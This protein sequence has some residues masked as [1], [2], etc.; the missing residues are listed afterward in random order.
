ML[1]IAILFRGPVRPSIQST[2]DR[3][4]EV[5]A[6]FAGVQNAEITTYLATWRS[7]KHLNATDLIALNLFDNVIMQTPPTDETIQR[8]TKLHRVPSSSPIRSVFTQ[9]YQ[10]KTALDLIVNADRYDFIVHTRTDLQLI[11]GQHLPQWFD[12]NFYVT[13]H[14]FPNEW[15]NDQAGIAPTEMM[16]KAWNY[17]TI[18]NLGRMIE[19][20]EKPEDVLQ[21]M[22]EKNKIPIRTAPYL[23]WNLDPMRNRI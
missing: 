4:K 13:Q 19:A 6:Q 23:M 18:E 15:T 17:E 7:Y 2:I 5:M 10:S 22:I 21:M 3:Y 1:K 11:L 16:Y 12:Q 14:V 9:F 20:C 8:C